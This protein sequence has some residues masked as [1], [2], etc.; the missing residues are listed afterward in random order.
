MTVQPPGSP[1]TPTDEP[2]FRTAP[3]V[4]AE[5]S[6][7]RTIVLH[8]DG[9]VISTLSPVGS[10]IWQCLPATPSAMLGVLTKHFAE[11][12]NERL[13]A[14]LTAFLTELEAQRLVVGGDAR[15]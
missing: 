11:V 2:I 14:D 8:A 7:D 3:G 12:S 6:G 15:A 4:A 5:S 13:E 1:R 9:S 10:L